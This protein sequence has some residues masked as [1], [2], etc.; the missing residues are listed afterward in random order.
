MPRLLA[1][2]PRFAMMATFGAFGLAMGLWSGSSAAILTRIH[3]GAGFFGLALTVFTGAYL[4]AMAS[5]NAIA[6]VFTLKRTLLLCLAAIGPTLA[7]VTLASSAFEF[8]A[9]LVV[10]GALSG[11]LDGAMNAE[12]SRIERKLARPIFLALHGAASSGGA[13]GAIVGSALASGPAPWMASVIGAA[14]L[15]GAA[16]SVQ[17]AI[18]GDA[19]DA[20]ENVLGE[21]VRVIT[22]SLV[23][24]GLTIGV[25]IACETAAMSWS[26][27]L[28]RR[29]APQWAALAGMGAS[30]FSA[31]QAAVRLN[32]DW[33]RRHVSDRSLITVSLAA[34]AVGFA[35]VAS[36]G[37]FARSVIG[38]AIVGAGTAAVVP[39]G[40][41]LAVSRPGVP[42]GA[43]ISAVSFFGLFA[44]LP[45]PLA[46]GALA[47][48][49]SLSTAFACLAALLI[50]SVGAVLAFIPD[51]P[52]RRFALEQSLGK[53]GPSP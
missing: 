17:R 20:P 27:L 52:R 23:V 16:F 51:A 46:T 8:A 35:V 36:E 39:C 12:G 34:A 19:G 15:L 31:C 7:L 13:L 10:Q 11:L 18:A 48:A 42:A 5:A 41:A 4:V 3:M 22:R 21:P 40:F 43:A 30:F 1:P 47:N 25:S 45:A 32:A 14:G 6:R 50:V 9:A 26:P 33:L 49:F 44:R 37:G 38:F 24:L 53:G 29:E 28:L 2:T